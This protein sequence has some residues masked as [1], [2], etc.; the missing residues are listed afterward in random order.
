V[1]RGGGETRRKI[2]LAFAVS[3]TTAM[4]LAQ[5]VSA[6]TFSVEVEDRPGD[7]AKMV[8]WWETYEIRSLYKE[9]TQIAQ[10]GYLDMT[11]VRFAL[12][13][14]TYTFGMKV[15]ADLPQRGDALPSGVRVVSWVL[16][17]DSVPFDFRDPVDD[18]FILWLQ[19]DESGYSANLL[20]VGTAEMVPLYCE[21]EPGTSEFEIE[22]SYDLF[23][24]LSTLWLYAGV[25]IFYSPDSVVLGGTGAWFTVDVFDPGANDYQVLA[26]IP[27]PQP[28]SE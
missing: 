12:D 10:A 4:M 23:G 2:V 22:F 1:V 27:F 25:K 6:S 14:D 8:D 15:A 24:S 17:F 5:P 18:L 20:N 26:S 21:P 11:F 3:F 16:W 28:E 13:E 19:F 9:H 7:V